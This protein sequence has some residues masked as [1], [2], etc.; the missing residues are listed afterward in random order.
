M[1]EEMKSK[2]SSSKREYG[3]SWSEQYSILFWR[4]LKERKNDYFSWLRITQVLATATILGLLW[5]QSG[6]DNPKELQDQVIYINFSKSLVANTNKITQTKRVLVQ[7]L[8]PLE[9]RYPS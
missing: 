6:S 9:T 5:W 8:I 3:A 1:D 2:L 4:G 7:Y